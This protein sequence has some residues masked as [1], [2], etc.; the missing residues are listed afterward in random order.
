LLPIPFVSGPVD[1]R[2]IV[3]ILITYSRDKRI[4]MKGWLVIIGC[5]AALVAFVGF[6]YIIGTPA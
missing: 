5:L 1:R 6:L 3:F 4:I 2:C